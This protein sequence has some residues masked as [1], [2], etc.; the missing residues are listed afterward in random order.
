MGIVGKAPPPDSG[1]T[2]NTVAVIGAGGRRARYSWNTV[3]SK[4]W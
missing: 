4:S 3:I 1:L 2:S